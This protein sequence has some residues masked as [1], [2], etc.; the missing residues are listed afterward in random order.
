MR[1]VQAP[2]GLLRVN[3]YSPQMI[4]HLHREKHATDQGSKT[5]IDDILETVNMEIL[6]WQK[7][8]IGLTDMW[9]LPENEFVAKQRDLVDFVDWALNWRDG[10][11]AYKTVHGT[12]LRKQKG[13]NWVH[14][15]G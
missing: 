3:D 13:D 11:D 9:R 7:Q 4:A 6:T 10:V 12:E 8:N 15:T 1:Q 5:I 14:G 2:G